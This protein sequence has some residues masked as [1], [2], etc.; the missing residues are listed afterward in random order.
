[1]VDSRHA[2]A[3]RARE[4]HA[5]R[6]RELVPY[7]CV[8]FLAHSKTHMSDCW[9][10]QRYPVYRIHA[11]SLASHAQWHRTL[12]GIARSIVPWSLRHD[13]FICH[14]TRLNVPHGSLTYATWLIHM[15]D[16][17]YAPVWYAWFLFEMKWL[18][19]A[20]HVMS[21]DHTWNNS[22]MWTR[23]MT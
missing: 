9:L 23:H 7:S 1:M 4:R 14:M 13:S 2:D 12:I 11:Q 5:E 16:M 20:C 3:E 17:W 6:A 22:F 8:R 18:L 19:H 15:C 10:I 21:F